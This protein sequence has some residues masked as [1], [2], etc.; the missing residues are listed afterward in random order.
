[1]SLNHYGLKVHRFLCGLKVLVRRLNYGLKWEKVSL[2]DDYSI[3]KSTKSLGLKS[4]A[5]TTG[6]DSKQLHKNPKA[7]VCFY[8]NPTDLP[9]AKAMRL[10]GDAEFLD[11]AELKK[12][13]YKERKFLDD[14]AGQSVEPFM[15]VFRIKTGEAHFWTML[16]VLKEPELERLRF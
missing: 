8:N 16:D 10:T 5:L 11:D 4:I 15:E 6:L 2:R 3:D 9:N 13:V 14:L 7:E 1:M 12:K